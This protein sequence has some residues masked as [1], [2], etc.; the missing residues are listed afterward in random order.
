M[1]ILLIVQ[2]DKQA[3]LQ[4]VCQWNDIGPLVGYMFSWRVVLEELNDCD[5]V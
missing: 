3:I 2:N 5:R 1:N 4:G